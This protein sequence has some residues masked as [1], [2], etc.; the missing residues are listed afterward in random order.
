[1]S[2]YAA[3]ATAEGVAG[4]ALDDPEGWGLPNLLR[5]AFGLAAHGAVATPT[6][7]GSTDAGGRRYLTLTFNRRASATDLTYTVQSSN[8]LVTWATLAT[9]PPGAPTTVTVQDSVA[10]GD[11]TRRFL[12]VRVSLP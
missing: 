5:Y 2:G 11:A 3:W 6:V 9:C 12:R 8:D 10:L 4:G 1:M 7:L